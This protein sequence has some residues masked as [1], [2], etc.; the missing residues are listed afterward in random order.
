MKDMVKTRAKPKTIHLN[1][2]ILN[3]KTFISA[4]PALFLTYFP[5]LIII[6]NPF[7]SRFLLEGTEHPGIIALM[8]H[9]HFSTGPVGIKLGRSGDQAPLKA[10][11]PSKDLGIR[12][13]A[14]Q[15]MTLASTIGWT[16]AFK[17]EYVK[18]DPDYQGT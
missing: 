12:L 10:R 13:S 9:G 17:R 7:R 6:T 5:W 16:M 11:Y 18:I 8:K 3:Q 4:S 2:I 14:C 15:G 1:F